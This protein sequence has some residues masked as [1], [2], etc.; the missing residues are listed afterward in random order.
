LLHILYER[1]FKVRKRGLILCDRL[2]C[3]Q[4]D[5]I[6]MAEITTKRCGELLRGVFSILFDK[7]EGMAAKDV[8]AKLE[9]TVPPTTYEAADYPSSPGVRRFEKTV[10]FSTIPAVKAGWLIKSKGTWSLSDLGKAAFEKY[11]NPEEFCKR[12]RTLFYDWKKAQPETAEEEEVVTEETAATT[13][14]E[15]EEA[16]WD[17]IEKYLRTMP[18]YDFQALVAALLRAMGYFVA[19]NAPP[20]PDGGVD[21]IAYTD[22]LGTRNP[23]IKVQVKRRQDSVNVEGLRSF[24]ALLSEQDVGIFVAISGFTKDAELEARRQES[25]RLTLVDLKTLFDLWVQNY[26]KVE[27]TEKHLLPL[28]RVFYLSP[29]D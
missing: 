29:P 6:G 8:L 14:E 21:I 12:A 25:R 10:R 11:T 4:K 13:I 15:A 7:P 2:R 19:W 24:M 16:A 22:A 27:Q 9:K 28:R 3:F 5:E 17:E 1:R 20:G 23:R 26:E 18:P